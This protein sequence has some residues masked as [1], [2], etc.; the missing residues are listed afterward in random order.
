M[1]E[2]SMMGRQRKK[3]PSYKHMIETFIQACGLRKAELERL[4]VRD[5]YRGGDHD[6]GFEEQWIHVDAFEDIPAHEV[7]FMGEERIIAE[8]CKGRNSDDLVFPVL[9]ELDYEGLR[10]AYADELFLVYYD[11]LGATGAPHSI[12]E[13]G[14]LL[15][16]ALGLRHYD[17]KRRRLMRWASQDMRRRLG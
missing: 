17:E 14:Q 2:R 4:R 3:R 5:I 15:K 7:P 1:L 6:F 16:E 11:S 8:V 10:E 13:L 9:P 12:S